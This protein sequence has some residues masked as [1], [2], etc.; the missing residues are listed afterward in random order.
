MECQGKGSLENEE[1]ATTDWEDERQQRD[2]A[3]P[4]YRQTPLSL[5]P[6]STLLPWLLE[7]SAAWFEFQGHLESKRRAGCRE[8]HFPALSSSH[9]FPEICEAVLVRLSQVPARPLPSQQRAVRPNSFSSRPPAPTLRTEKGGKR[10][11]P[12]PLAWLLPFLP[13]LLCSLARLPSPSKT[14]KITT[15]MP[16]E[17]QGLFSPSALTS[18]LLSTWLEVG[19]SCALRAA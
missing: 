13:G 2:V 14:S 17:E 15:L 8:P 4:S 1:C 19:H 12:V 11:T 10:S 16:A 3:F 5:S 7:K 9:I 6:S 18:V